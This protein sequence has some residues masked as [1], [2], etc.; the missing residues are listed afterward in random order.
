LCYSQ[1]GA[2]RSCAA[3]LTAACRSKRYVPALACTRADRQVYAPGR[4]SPKLPIGRT[5]SGSPGASGRNWGALDLVASRVL[6][7]AFE[8]PQH[9]PPSMADRAAPDGR[10][11]CLSWWPGSCLRPAARWTG[12]GQVRP[13]SRF[14]GDAAPGAPAIR[15]SRADPLPSGWLPH[16]QREA[17]SCPTRRPAPGRAARRPSSHSRAA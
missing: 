11:R 7:P 5:Y 8:L 3:G 4:L 16:R 14:R 13:G 6:Q 2:K 1:G 15:A 10:P 17:D 12:T 9:H